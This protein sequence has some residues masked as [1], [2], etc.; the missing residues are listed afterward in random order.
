MNSE[1]I[2]NIEKVDLHCVIR[3]MTGHIYH[4]NMWN[5]FNMGNLLRKITEIMETEHGEKEFNCERILFFN[6]EHERIDFM[7]DLYVNNGDYFNLVI[8]DEEQLKY[9]HRDWEGKWANL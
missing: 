9:V 4:I 3:L 5:G 2:E 1:N 8:V 6:K 7:D